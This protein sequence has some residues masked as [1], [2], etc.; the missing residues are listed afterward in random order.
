MHRRAAL[1][2]AVTALRE[3][4]G[5]GP[6]RTAQLELLRGSGLGRPVYWLKAAFRRSVSDF[7]ITAPGFAGTHVHPQKES[8]DPL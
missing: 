8:A 7:D 6:G 2:K 1:I 3:A 5:G 4:Q